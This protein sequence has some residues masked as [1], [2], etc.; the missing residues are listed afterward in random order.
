[1]VRDFGVYDATSYS[2]LSVSLSPNRQTHTPKC[3]EQQQQQQPEV[4]SWDLDVV[5]FRIC[6]CVSL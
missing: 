1:M 4:L 2:L 3:I 5:K 6:H